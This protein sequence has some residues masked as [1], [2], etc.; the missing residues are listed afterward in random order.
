MI[1]Y[2]LCLENH[3]EDEIICRIKKKCYYFYVVIFI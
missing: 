2:I 3:L 1:I